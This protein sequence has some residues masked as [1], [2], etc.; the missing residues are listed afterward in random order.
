[1]SRLTR[2][3]SLGARRSGISGRP[4]RPGRRASRPTL[5]GA[6]ALAAT[7]WSGPALAQPAPAPPPIP[8]PPAAQPAPAAEPSAPPQLDADGYG[9]P[10]PGA[11]PEL[12]PRS[13]LAPGQKRAPQDYDGRE[14]VTTAA[15][16]ALWVP[17][18]LFYPLYLVSEYV[19]R[20][21]LG[22]LTVAVEE[23]DV[24]SELQKFFTFGP[25]DNIG[26]I[27]TGFLDFGFRPS[28]GV[29]FFYNDFLSEGND[30]RANFSFGGR[31]FWRLSAADRIPI[32]M[33]IG[34][35][36]SKS[37]FQMEAS[38]LTRPDLLFWGI[39]P[40]VLESEGATFSL[41]TVGGG[42]RI[43]IEPWRGTFLEAWVTGRYTTTGA[44]ECGGQVSF[45]DEQEGIGQICDPP[46]IR[47]SILD[48]TFEPPPHYGRPYATVKS[49]ISFAID[50]REPR[51]APGTGVAFEAHAEH[52][53][54][55]KEPA[56]GG[57]I[58]Y[59]AALAGF[60]D[61][62]GTQRVLGLT[63]AAFFQDPLSSETIIPFT[64]RVGA[65]HIEDVPDL[66][67]MRGFKPGFLLGS[68]AIAA[69]L[70]YRWPIWAFLDGTLQASV[71]NS[72]AETHLEDFDAEKLRF[73][74]LGGI[75][76]PNHRDHSFNL[77][78]G[79]GTS[80]F[81]QGGEPTMVRFVFGGTTGF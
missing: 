53:A 31:S 15:E 75:R 1:M 4:M 66:D 32:H 40:D 45:V 38:F 52:V 24:I 10:R 51:P 34:Q 33:P 18:V 69:T 72:F 50:S 65:K 60:I 30:L 36:R 54:E 57:W 9:G 59:S 27:P 14:D 44:G 80:T 25:N 11:R 29:Y 2:P 68:S 67:I 47:R 49:G 81:E 6:I 20:I 64:E 55:V 74:F 8:P 22:A 19:I 23:N 7:C 56:Q 41:F 71:G 61:L 77:L 5:T 3:L 28:I 58:N 78:I 43:H 35:E 73:S 16:D 39:G 17:R 13:D 63:V 26:I 48:G 70:D 37:Y 12:T 76:S 42:A 79:F 62:T 21:P 46:T